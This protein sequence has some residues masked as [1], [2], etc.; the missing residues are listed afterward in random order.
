MTMM[1]MKDANFFQGWIDKVREALKNEYFKKCTFEVKHV[2]RALDIQS[3]NRSAA[4]FIGRALDRL[5]SSGLLE[6]IGSPLHSPKKY[7]IKTARSAQ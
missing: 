7:K 4:L 6:R 1:E 2:R 3:N 5:V